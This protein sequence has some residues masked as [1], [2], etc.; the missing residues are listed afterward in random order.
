MLVLP[1]DAV[2]AYLAYLLIGRPL[3]QKLA[4]KEPTTP[5]ETSAPVTQEVAADAVR[6]RLLLAQYSTRGVTPLRR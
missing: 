5:E 2:P 4:G 6:T 1:P 3:V